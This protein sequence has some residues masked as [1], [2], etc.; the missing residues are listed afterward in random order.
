MTQ[1]GLIEKITATAKMEGC[2]PD[3]TPTTL[4]A[5]GSD[6]EG[7][8]WNQDHWDCAS[9]VGMLLCVSNNTRPDIAFAVSQVARHTACPKESHAR[10]VQ[11]IIQCLAGTV[12]RGL[13]LK[14]DGAFDLKAWADTDFAGT[15]GQEPGGNAK[16]V[17]S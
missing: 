13:T 11:H 6:A 10:A 7:A 17:K 5:L 2:N 8:P 3:K 4:A 16:S 9:I 14:H 15:F 12:N 1:K